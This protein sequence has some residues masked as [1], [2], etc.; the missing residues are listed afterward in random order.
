M[1]VVRAR[2][3]LRSDS[4]CCNLAR[5]LSSASRLEDQA[6]ERSHPDEASI[7]FCSLLRVCVWTLLGGDCRGIPERFVYGLGA[8]QP[9]HQYGELAGHGDDRS[10]LCVGS[11]SCGDGKAVTAQIAVRAERTQHVMCAVDQKTS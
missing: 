6:G 9:M 7:F 10:F 11:S 8:P 2:C 4:G 5:G 3:M 1:S